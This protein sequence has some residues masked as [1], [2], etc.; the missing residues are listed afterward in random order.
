M[1]AVW[2]CLTKLPELPWKKGSRD[3]DFA[4]ALRE[5]VILSQGSR[6]KLQGKWKALRDQHANIGIAPKESHDPLEYIHDLLEENKIESPWTGTHVQE[7][8]CN[9]CED[10]HRREDPIDFADVAANTELSVQESAQATQED[11]YRTC[12]VMV[13]DNINFGQFNQNRCLYF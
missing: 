5:Y 11:V 7:T 9:A 12:N 1:A 2:Q 8:I 4:R 13:T 6:T 3:E 10:A